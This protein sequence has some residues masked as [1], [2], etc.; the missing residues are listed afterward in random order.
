[1]KH[2]RF[3]FFQCL[4]SKLDEVLAFVN[5]PSIMPNSI[6]VEY[7]ESMGILLISIG[8]SETEGALGLVGLHRVK[9]GSINNDS[10][11]LLEQ[12]MSQE[13]AAL[14]GVIC[15]EMYVD[16]QGDMHAIFMTEA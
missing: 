15:H 13:A 3:R 5:L 6:G 10:L 8:Y 2:S 16:A 12:R 1:M 14:D 4:D 11:A 9:L 7:L